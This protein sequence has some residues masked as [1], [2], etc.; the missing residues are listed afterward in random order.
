MQVRTRNPN[1]VERNCMASLPDG[2]SLLVNLDGVNIFACTKENQ[3]VF[4]GSTTWL[5]QTGGLQFEDLTGR[6]FRRLQVTP[7]CFCVLPLDFAHVEDVVMKS[8]G[9][10]LRNVLQLQ[11]NVLLEKADPVTI[12]CSL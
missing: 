1:S 7:P 12:E 8:I 10:K 3:V 6:L 9:G 4:V 5:L 11:Q 2:K